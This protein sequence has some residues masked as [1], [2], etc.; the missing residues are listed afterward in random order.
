LLRNWSIHEI[1]P[2][3][4][5]Q[6]LIGNSLSVL[7][8]NLCLIILINLS[9]YISIL[10]IFILTLILNLHY[11]LA[12]LIIDRVHHYRVLII[13][14]RSALTRP[15]LSTLCQG[16]LSRWA[17]IIVTELYNVS[18]IINWGGTTTTTMHHINL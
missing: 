10:Y 7:L 14:H 13:V 12:N 11:L 15:E 3:I 2:S 5:H 9:D 17:L 4:Y 16:Y 1:V 6:V 18:T 8:G